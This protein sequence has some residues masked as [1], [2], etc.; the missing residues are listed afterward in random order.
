MTSSRQLVHIASST[1]RDMVLD[2][3]G[4]LPPRGQFVPLMVKKKSEDREHRQTWRLTEVGGQRGVEWF[5]EVGDREQ[6]GGT[7]VGDRE[8]RVWDGS[9]RWGTG[10]RGCGMAHRGGGTEGSGMV[11]RGGSQRWGTEV[12]DRGGG[13]QRWGTEG[14]GWLTE[15]GDRGGSQRWGTEGGG[16]AHR[17]GGQRGVG[18]FTEVGDRGGG[19]LRWFGTMLFQRP[20]V[21]QPPVVPTTAYVVLVYFSCS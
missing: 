13:G 5:T 20:I 4:Q 18:W 11:H 8:Q 1:H 10:N 21:M 19:I 7:E 9:Q 2:I 15:V 12:G 17:G 16:M 14:V 6:R 3:A